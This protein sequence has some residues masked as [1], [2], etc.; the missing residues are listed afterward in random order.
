MQYDAV[1]LFVERARL[2]SPYFSRGSENASDV[3]EICQRLDGLPLA[4]EL[5]SARLNVLTVQE[6]ASR[7]D[8]RFA[9]LTS[10]QRSGLQPRH[11]Q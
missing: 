2:F 10:G 6:I 8:D 1:R 4:L 11:Q 9:L 3:A 7:L 5:A